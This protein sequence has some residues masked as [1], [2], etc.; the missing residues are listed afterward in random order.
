MCYTFVSFRTND[1]GSTTCTSQVVRL[2]PALDHGSYLDICLEDDSGHVHDLQLATIKEVLLQAFY[3][4][5]VTLVGMELSHIPLTLLLEWNY[6]TQVEPL[7]ADMQSGAGQSGLM[8]SGQARDHKVGIRAP[9]R[10]YN[11]RELTSDVCPKVAIVG[12]FISQAH[13][14]TTL[15]TPADRFI[16]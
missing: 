5:T 4:S 9:R 6:T 1:R 12:E 10:F 14:S 2:H 15:T 3:I 7:Q 16:S 8:G 13:R 11:A